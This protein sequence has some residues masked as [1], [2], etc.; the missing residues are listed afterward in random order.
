ME[1][2]TAWADLQLRQAMRRGEFDDLPGL[3]KPLTGL[4]DGHD[5]DWW[6]KR[7][8]EREKIA[9]LPPALQLRRDDEQL[10]EVLDRLPNAD[11]VRR[12]VTAFNERVRR[13]LYSTTGWPPVTTGPRDVEHEVERWRERLAA[14]RAQAAAQQPQADPRRRRWWRR[15]A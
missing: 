3:G 7:L 8:V 10:D 1:Q 11:E 14:R 12:E 4:G 15:R 13:T 9:V 5:P 6:V 2:H